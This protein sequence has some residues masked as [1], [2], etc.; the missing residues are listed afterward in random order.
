[1]ALAITLLLSNKVPATSDSIGALGKL[2]RQKGLCYV[3]YRGGHYV[4]RR[5][6]AIT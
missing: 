2:I 1:L 6:G 5:P 3:E 4:S